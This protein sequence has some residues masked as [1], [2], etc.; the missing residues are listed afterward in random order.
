MTTSVSC[1]VCGAEPREDARFCDSCGSP[2]TV[3]QRAEYKQVTVLFADVVHS[4]DIAAAVG[5]ERLREIMTDLIRDA[6]A[7]VQRYGGTV[8]QFTGDGL[9][10][11]FG[12]PIALEDHAFRACLAAL[13]IQQQ[14]QYLG[15]IVDR[16]DGV[17]LKLRIGLNSGEVI[18]GEMRAGP[19]NYAT[20]GEQVGMAQRMES[21]A[22]PGGAMLS[23]TTARLVEDNVTLGDPEKVWIKG[24][25]APVV[26]RRLIA[27]GST[28]RRPARQLSTLIGRDWELSSISAMLDQAMKGKGCIVG[29]VGPPGIGKSRMTAEITSVAV[30]RS[31]DVFTTRCESHAK[32]IPFQAAAGL[33]RDIYAIIGL[34]AASARAAVHGRMPA[35]DP[36]DLLLLDDLLGIHDGAIALPAV[37]PDARSRRLAALL[38]AAA[39]DRSTPAVYVVED[40]HWIDSVSEK[41]IAQFAAVVPQ[42]H[43]MLLVTYRPEYVGVLSHL[44]GAH[45]IALAPLDDSESAQLATELCGAD[46][47]VDLLIAQVAARAAGNPFFAEEIVRDLAERG[48][49]EGRLGDYVFRG[50]TAE[51]SVPASLQATIAARI[52]RLRP[53][54][55]RTVTAASVIG[56]QFDTDLLRHLVDDIDVAELTAAELIDQVSFVANSEYMFR[57]P[58]IRT[59]A[60][61]SQLKADRA[62]LHRQAATAIEAR[63]SDGPEPS[64]ALIAQHLEAAGDLR[65]A[66]DWHM[67]AAAWAQFRDFRAAR[68]SWEQ[69]REVA[70]RLRPDDPQKPLLQIGPRTALCAS[71]FRFSG[72]VEDTKFEE[73]RELCVSVGDNLSLALGMAGFL[74]AL[75]FHNRFRDASQVASDLSA[76]LDLI[77]EPALT[78]TLCTA[79]S[80]AKWQAGEAVEALRL[81]QRAIDLAE[82]DP[83][84]DSVIIG[85]PLTLAL[86]LR[87]A[88]RLA[89][90][91]DGWREDLDRAAA[92]AISIDVT[93]HIAAILVKHGF[94]VYIGAL[95]PGAMAW[96]ETA[97]A[98]LLAQRCGDD[99]ALDSAR[100]TRGVVL[101]CGDG[102]QR[103]AGLEL[104]DLYRDS[105]QRHGYV[106]GV[107]RFTST[108]VAREMAR[109]S[110]IDGAIQTARSAVDYFF[111]SGD[112]TSR[113]PA[114][115]IL[116]ESLLRR[117]GYDD[118]LEAGNVI[119]RLAAV[120]VDPGFVLY[121]LPL[122]RMRALLAQAHGDNAGYRDFADKYRDMANSLG[123]EGHIAIAATMT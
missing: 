21:V 30:G 2:L 110:D 117:G 89:L 12:A 32:E 42:A 97:D 105:S 67:R 37:E 108:E 25:D 80:N 106:T 13:D 64:A 26:A 77:N 31:C 14:V 18:A 45:R 57:H 39:V 65:A 53:A 9:M 60:Y 123:F 20:I 102:D 43:A 85:S 54:A 101:A 51:V 76:M 83:T 75:I 66:F 5:P 103:T 46:T 74:T 24:S 122:R 41:M 86:A 6:S 10:A 121:E 33:L 100:L 73:L 93:S 113:G 8:S 27:A 1:R 120:P 23:E 55:K 29:L 112:A 95:V 63:D 109:I 52:D 92:M 115:A 82:D 91:I 44:P 16:R 49:L 119:E 34:D 72:S 38:N 90:G 88:N 116:V 96:K 118:R 22:P 7:A 19:T 11:V 99:F 70:D 104:L 36:E 59:V 35:A 87:G 114:V 17:E 69:A 84:R 61:E 62:Q 4:M 79:A 48:V 58:L 68:T 107:A 98:L 78:L 28:T 3:G 81:A 71:T 56:S 47:S 15:V 40:A 94:A 50:D 111:D